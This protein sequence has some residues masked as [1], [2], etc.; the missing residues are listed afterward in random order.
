[1]PEADAVRSQGMR[2][3]SPE[4]AGTANIPAP[5]SGGATSPA[6]TRVKART[7]GREAALGP[8]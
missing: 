8:D 4:K 1:M 3:T 2:A 7:S 5:D 6:R